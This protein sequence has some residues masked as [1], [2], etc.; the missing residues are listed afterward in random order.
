MQRLL[1][2]V[3]Q[4]FI[5]R[6]HFF[7]FLFFG[8]ISPQI[9]HTVVCVCTK[10]SH[11]HLFS[12]FYFFVSASE[13]FFSFFFR[14]S[15]S[16]PPCNPACNH[17]IYT[18]QTNTQG[19]IVYPVMASSIFTVTSGFIF[20][21]YFRSGFCLRIAGVLRKTVRSLCTRKVNKRTTM[22]QK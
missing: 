18:V 19:Y 7:L 1:V 12:H 22:W 2:C 6:V 10:M 21:I 3:P 15:L 8:R 9:V 17:P 16:S 14:C 4:I 13:I 11:F 20:F 5:L